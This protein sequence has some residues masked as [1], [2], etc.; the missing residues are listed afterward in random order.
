MPHVRVYT[1]GLL[2][3]GGWIAPCVMHGA[4]SSSST[5]A[6]NAAPQL[7]RS[8]V[9][10]PHGVV[11]SSHPL[12]SQAGLDVLKRGGNAIDAAVTA[13]A[14]MNFTE[15]M[16]TGIGGD[17]FAIIW[18]AREQRLVGL[19]ASGR[20]GSLLSLDTLRAAGFSQMPAT[21]ALSVTVPGALAG[22]AALLERYG[23]ISLAEAIEPA[24]RLAEEGF[25][26][27]PV[28]AAH[29]ESAEPNLA[30]D[31][32]RVFQI[33]GGR[34]PR[35]GEWYANPD[36]ART[37]RAIAKHGPGLFYGGEL[38][39]RIVE[40]LRPLG[41]FLT[42]ED[43]KQH[44]NEWVEPM[45]ARFRGYKLWELPPNGQGIAALEMVRIL[46]P[47]DLAAMGHNSADYLHHLIEA[48]KLA[49]ADLEEFVGD[50]EIMTMRPGR[51]LD[52]AFI[53][54]RRSRLDPKRAQLRPA[55]GPALGKSETT[56]L[57]AADRAGNM[58]SFINSVSGLYGSGIVV[59]GT[60]FVLQ[61][62]GSGF[63][64]TEGRVNTVAPRR[65]PFHTII[66]GFITRTGAD[67][68]DEPW[69]SF[70]I[71]G[72]PNQPQ[73]HVQ[74]MLNLVV[75]GMDAQAALDAPRFRHV[76]DQRVYFDTRL[77]PSTISNLLARGHVV[78]PPLNHSEG[79]RFGTGHVIRRLPRGYEAGSDSRNDG[80]PAA[81]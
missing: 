43:L 70:G 51:L 33:E 4:E 49:Y 55:P 57:T 59:P 31:S 63:T 5:R 13:A 76:S 19:N 7:N 61:N 60:G 36:L 77:T 8:P 45:A 15:P 21:G 14:V 66:P 23:T 11:A 18:L 16:M 44:K 50:P 47:I 75:F 72:G 62:R 81:H 6:G 46:E 56:Y 42:L 58:I 69:V 34:P 39:A 17:M 53:A 20:G 29:F 1:V 48:K 73:A 80:L 79:G 22:W 52:D 32:R 35:T 12:A 65:R 74:V 28:I 27:P 24:A 9:F 40:H 41:G 71:M 64:M 25:P 78:E 3:L 10:A 68:R 54:E 30:K 26:L 38:G 37:F 67:G 2:V